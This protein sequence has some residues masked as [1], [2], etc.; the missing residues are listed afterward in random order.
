MSAEHKED[1]YELTVQT[2]S[3]TRVA[4]FSLYADAMAAYENARLEGAT[5]A[6]VVRVQN[7]PD[8]MHCH[9]LAVLA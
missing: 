7:T 9:R 8:G 3:G 5:S 4:R 2:G 6:T 1:F